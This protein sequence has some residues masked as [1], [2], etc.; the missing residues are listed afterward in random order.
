MNITRNQRANI[1]AT[2]ILIAYS[3]LIYSV[4]G[5]T[6]IGTFADIIS[7]LAVIGIPILLFPILHTEGNK[8]LNSLYILA[9]FIEGVL[10]IIGGV[11]LLIPSRVEYRDHIY[12]DIHIYF[13]IAGAILLYILLYRTQAVPI[14]ISIWGIAA[15]LILFA[16]TI[17]RLFGIESPML[18]ILLLPIVLNELYLAFW[19]FFKGFQEMDHA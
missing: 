13:F 8:Q 16:A 11:L 15:T 10:M 12:S 19:L 1:V 17:V 7:G 3:M 5:N 18:D 6:V 4:T 2:L 14:F 9:R